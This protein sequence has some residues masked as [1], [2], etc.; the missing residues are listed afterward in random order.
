MT[1]DR[2]FCRFSKSPAT[3]AFGMPEVPKD[4]LCLCAFVVITSAEPPSR[5]LLGRINPEAPW[6][7]L[8]ALDPERVTSWKDRWMLP[9]SHL[10]MLESP[11]E[12]ASRIL[13]ELTGLSGRTLEGPKVTSEVYAAPRNPG[14]AHHWDIEFIF[15]GTASESEVKPIE[16]W[17]ELRFVELGQLQPDN[18]ARL[19]DDI[20]RYVGLVPGK[21]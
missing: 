11:E 17:T 20:L 15:R 4:G 21:W 3:A 2:T 16:P 9:S 1:T 13:R 12:A 5:V 7:H 18:M 10:L 14:A 6:D 19:Q 8:G